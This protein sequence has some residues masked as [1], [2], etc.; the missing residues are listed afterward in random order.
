MS[1]PQTLI[2]RELEVVAVDAAGNSPAPS[3]PVTGTGTNIWTVVAVGA[4]GNRSAP[5]NPAAVAVT[6]DVA[7]C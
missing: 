1:S 6:A 5:S 7:L 4:A 2:W 3:A